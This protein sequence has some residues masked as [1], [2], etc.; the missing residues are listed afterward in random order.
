[1]IEKQANFVRLKNFGAINNPDGHG[2]A[3]NHCGET[4]EIFLRV[5]NGRVME[6]LFFTDGCWHTIQAGAA[7]AGLTAEKSGM[8]LEV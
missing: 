5:H 2:K 4:L 8:V 7:V 3:L 6:S 1:M